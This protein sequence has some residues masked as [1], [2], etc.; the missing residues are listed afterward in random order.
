ML[1]SH[2]IIKRVITIFQ[3]PRTILDQ[4]LV[5]AAQKLNAK[6]QRLFHLLADSQLTDA[7]RLR[8]FRAAA[9]SS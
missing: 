6:S 5:Q 3:K 2:E 1:F 8:K 7:L 4:Y 9:E